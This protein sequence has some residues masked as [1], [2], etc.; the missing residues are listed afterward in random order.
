M[1][2]PPIP[3]GGDKLIQMSVVRTL[4]TRFTSPRIVYIS[5]TRLS[6]RSLCTPQTPF[7]YHLDSSNCISELLSSW[8]QQHSTL[9]PTITFKCLMKVSNLIRTSKRYDTLSSSIFK[10]LLKASTDNV[11]LLKPEDL[12]LLLWLMAKIRWSDYATIAKLTQILHSQIPNLS[13][14]SLNLIIWS[15]VTLKVNERYRIIINEIVTEVVNRLKLEQFHD[16]RGLANM[17]WSLAKAEMWPKY[18]TAHV[19]KFLRTQGH[20]ISPHSL[21]MFLHSLSKSR[22]LKVDN[23]VFNVITKMVSSFKDTDQQSLN[24]ILWS[25][26]TQKKYNKAFFERLR[27]EILSG[28]L[29]DCYNPRLLATIVWCCARCHY[30][31]HALFDHLTQQVPLHI[32]GMTTHD[33]VMVAYSF[34]YLNYSCPELMHSIADR[35]VDSIHANQKMTFQA[36]VNLSWACLINEI[37]PKDLYEICLSKESIERK[38]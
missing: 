9:P 32:D 33:L 37:Y 1:E 8:H 17:C 38:K 25:I 36:L 15:L 26:G 7:E 19:Q 20:N 35:V 22:V 28:S 18:L 2:P 14:K 3:R 34:G 24:L 16:H 5:F 6:S 23:Q 29:V 11:S 12:V 4:C 27:E 10:Q 30:Y 21:S 31:D 13:N